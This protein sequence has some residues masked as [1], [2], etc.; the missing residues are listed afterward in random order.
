MQAGLIGN[1]EMTFPHEIFRAYDIRGV[2]NQA[3]TGELVEQ[4]GRSV[5]TESR[6]KGIDTVVVGWDGRLSSPK[7]A[8]ALSSGLMVAGCRVLEIGQVPTPVLYQAAADHG[9]GTG[10]QI[11]GSHNPPGYNGLKIMINGQALSGDAIQHIK[12]RIRRQ[13]YAAGSG[14]LERLD[15]LPEYSRAVISDVHLSR[16]LKVVIDCGN[17]VAGN[18]APEI[19]RELGCEVME[20]FCEVDGNFPNHHPDPSQPENLRDLIVAVK[21]HGA[22]IGLALDGDGDRLGVVSSRGRIIWP[23][24]VMVLITEAV[25]AEHPGAEIIFDVKCSQVLHDAILRNGGRACMWKTGHSLIKAK[26]RET[27]AVFAGEMSGHLFFNDRWRGFDD[28]IYAGARLC[29][30]ISRQAGTSDQ[31]FAGIPDT[32]NTPELR[33]DMSEGGHHELV[34]ALVRSAHFPGA[35]VSTL[36][37]IRADYAEGFGLIRASNTTP[38]VIMR[39]EASDARRLEWIMARFRQQILKVRPGIVLPF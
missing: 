14:M 16:P 39:F 30:L 34:A 35:Q 12:E 4:I 7:L 20:L 8:D 29:E 32:I 38:S 6:E 25:L 17:G 33:L 10:V 21:R 11:T 5:G 37:G 1:R 13:D 2:V 31:L 26:L 36:D 19:F 9:S 3:L 24:R 15:Y 28:G 23:D 18:A 27:G 22:D